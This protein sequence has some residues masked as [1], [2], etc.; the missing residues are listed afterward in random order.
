MIC[1]SIYDIAQTTTMH[2][3]Q[4]QERQLWF[5]QEDGALELYT[6]LQTETVSKSW[7]TLCRKTLRKTS[8]AVVPKCFNQSKH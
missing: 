6:L 1:S 8:V 3:Q 5:Q 4:Q 7:R 2:R